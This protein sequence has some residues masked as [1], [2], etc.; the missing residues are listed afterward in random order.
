MKKYVAAFLLIAGLA[1][2][3]SIN[4]FHNPKVANALLT[5]GASCNI[6]DD[7]S[8]QCV[9]VGGTTY[10]AVCNGGVIGAGNQTSLCA[11]I[12]AGGGFGNTSGTIIGT[13]PVL[14]WTPSLGATY[15][16]VEVSDTP[17][18]SNV[19]FRKQVAGNSVT[20]Q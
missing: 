13:R 14:S 15:Y 9:D 1:V 8:N 11:G 16:V 19:V 2:L 20:V 4:Y 6:T 10:R 5:V 18:F 12:I 3:G 7:L 17:D